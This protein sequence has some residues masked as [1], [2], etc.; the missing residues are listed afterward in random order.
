MNSLIDRLDAFDEKTKN[1]NVI[2]E[3]PKGSRIKYSY[4]AESG[5]FALKRALP[6]GM[7]FPFNFGFIPGT[8]GEDGDPLDILILNEEP[9]LSGCLLKVRL[10][11]VIKAKQTEDEKAVRNDRLLG[12]AIRKETPTEMD[13]VKLD[14]R[15]L[16][17]IEHFFIS[18]NQLDGKKFKVLGQGSADKA[19][20]IVRAGVKQHRK[21]DKS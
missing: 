9:L 3:T 5:L 2:V 7:M 8:L 17:H 20:K 14:K 21:S 19:E 6:E 16:A 12:L 11:G 1:W 15:C 10:I 13:S 4:D 18:Y